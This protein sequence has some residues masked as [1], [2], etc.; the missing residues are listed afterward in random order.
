MKVP[1][2]WLREYVALQTSPSELMRH[3]TAIGHMQDGPA[4]EIAGDQVY[5]LEV[6]QN[7]SDCL[8]LVGVAR[9]AAAVL[10]AT[11][12][13]PAERSPELPAASG[14]I[15]LHIED[16]DLC[17]R[18]NTVTLT[19]VKVGPSPDWLRNRL[20]A[21]GMKS[22][23]TIVDI[24]NYVM[25]EQGQPLHAFDLDTLAGA[26]LHVRPAR[27]KETLVVLGSKTV[28]L[29]SDDLV[30]A[31][32]TGPVA[33]AGVIGGEQC[34]VSENTTTIVIEAATYNQASIRR[35][36]LRHTLRTEASTRLEK[37]LHP[38]LTTRALRRVTELVMQLAGGKIIDHT[39]AYPRP[40]AARVVQ[41]DPANVQRLG[42]VPLSAEQC[43]QLLSRLGIE[44]SIKADQTLSVSI[45]LWRTDLEQEADLIEEVLRLYGYE[46]IP[47]QLPKG[48]IPKDIQS[49][50]HILEEQLRDILVACGYDEQITEPLVNEAE[51][52]L[53]PVRLQNSLSSEK[54]MLRTSLTPQLLLGAQ[55]RLRY[56]QNDVRLFEVGKV[57]F[58]DGQEYKEKKVVSAILSGPSAKYLDLKGVAE[59]MIARTNRR[60]TPGLFTIE[61]LDAHTFVMTLETERL[62]QEPLEPS[63][64]IL[65]TPPQ[66]ILEDWSLLTP[67]DT[68]VGELLATIAGRSP[69]VSHVELGEDP[70]PLANNQKSVFVKVTYS[71]PTRTLSAAD[72]DPVRTDILRELATRFRATRR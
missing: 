6:R 23:N 69:L 54:V 32:Q 71:D 34:G 1:L 64:R 66:V 17:Y 14:A 5:D 55:N 65:T 2:S 44:N 8:S 25:I 24:T 50:S 13:D 62:L 61:I 56:R 39:D 31:D 10:E 21:Y 9:E 36:A 35:S 30:I 68:A 3:L 46:H 16:P 47:E 28:S 22:I 11:L 37:F 41:L 12:H 51:P 20:E 29:T 19:G 26:E 18:F 42:G 67:D 33:L 4:K 48:M 59:T 57:Y 15:K 53:N 27:E 63:V 60:N 7:R 70:R 38:E 49:R 72:V 40:L 43:Q 45:P 58:L 52:R